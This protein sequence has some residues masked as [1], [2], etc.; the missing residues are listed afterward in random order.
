MGIDL[1]AGGRRVGSHQRTEPKSNNVY[2]RLLVKLYR[3]LAR[4]TGSKVNKT[5]LQRLFMSK[6]NRPPLSLS[7]LAEHMKEK[8][9]KIAVV[10]GT[11]TDDVRLLEAPKLRVA[12]LRFTHT[13]R[14]RIVNAGGECLTFDQLALLSPTGEGAV[15]LRGSKAREAVKHFGAPGVPNSSAKC[16]PRRACCLRAAL[17]RRIRPAARR[18]ALTRRLPRAPRRP[19]LRAQAVRAPQGPQVREGTWPP[20]QPWLQGIRGAGGERMGHAASQ[21]GGAACSQTAQAARQACDAGGRIAERR[22]CRAG[23]G[24]RGSGRGLRGGGEPARC[25]SSRLAGG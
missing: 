1:K 11:I 20:P 19:A 17:R 7:K 2:I 4:R 24:A 25:W 9:D 21:D 6:V 5:I 8:S 12:A 22:A 10:V 14:A 23:R 3:F 13:A 15:L 16:A 18:P